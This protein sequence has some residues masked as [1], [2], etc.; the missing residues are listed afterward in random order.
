MPQG[1]FASKIEI[2]SD[3]VKDTREIDGGLETVS[4]NMASIITTD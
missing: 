4:L 1:T 2:E 3:K